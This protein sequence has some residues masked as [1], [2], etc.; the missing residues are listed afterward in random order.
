MMVLEGSAALRHMKIWCLAPFPARRRVLYRL[1]PGQAPGASNGP[2][3]R[4]DANPRMGRRPEPAA[5]AAV[6]SVVANPDQIAAD[7]IGNCSTQRS[8]DKLKWARPR[9][10]LTQMAA[11][12]DSHCVTASSS[13]RL[14]K[15]RAG[16]R[17]AFQAPILQAVLCQLVERSDFRAIV[18]TQSLLANHVLY[19]LCCHSRWSKKGCM[20]SCQSS[21]S[22]PAFVGH[23]TTSFRRGLTQ[24]CAYV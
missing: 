11:I 17:R 24:P 15:E 3:Q 10:S 20:L 13:H 14:T 22:C 19:T 2:F 16:S 5:M 12:K 21:R 18:F 7:H 23:K 6:C 8:A 1:L 4:K 9:S